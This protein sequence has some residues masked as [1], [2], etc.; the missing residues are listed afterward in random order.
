MSVCLSIHGNWGEVA[1]GRRKWGCELQSPHNNTTRMCFFYH[2][3]SALS[4]TS[5]PCFTHHNHRMHVFCIAPV[6]IVRVFA[7]LPFTSIFSGAVLADGD[8]GP[9]LWDGVTTRGKAKP[10]IAPSN[11]VALKSS[12]WPGT[13]PPPRFFTARASF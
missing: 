9:G 4:S 8:G 13:S 1:Q 2:C 11:C 6:V 5:Q 10:G 7:F 3:A 12:L